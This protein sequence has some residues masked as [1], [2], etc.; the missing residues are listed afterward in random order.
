MTMNATT[1]DGSARSSWEPDGHTLTIAMALQLDALQRGAPEV[2]AGRGHLERPVRWVHV[3]EARDIASVLRGGELLMTEGG[4]FRGPEADQRRFVIELAERGVAG[5]ILELGTYFQSVPAQLIAE[6]DRLELPLIAWH[7]P[8]PFIEVTEAIHRWIVNAQSAL[9]IEGEAVQRRL[10][11]LALAGASADDLVEALSDAVANPVV[12][13]REGG[14]VAYVARA[15]QSERDVFAA[16]ERF[17]RQLPD[18]P[19][20]IQRDLPHVRGEALGRIVAI[21][22][23]ASLGATEETVM[24]RV[25]GLIS[26]VLWQSRHEEAVAARSNRGFLSALLAGEIAPITANNRAVSSGFSAPVLLPIAV[27][28]ARHHHGNMV[29][30]EDRIWSQVWQQ[31]ITE[32]RSRG[33]PAIVDPQRTS[34]P[35]LTVLGLS[36][37]GQRRVSAARFAS[38]VSGIAGRLYDEEGT[39]VVCVG[40]AV[41][42]WPSA[43]EALGVAV[44]A[45]QGAAFARPRL[46]HDA[47]D[48]D[49]DRLLWSLRD[50]ADLAQFAHLR[51]DR[52]ETHD[53][54]RH[55]QLVAT[56]EAFLEHNG[57]KADTARALHLERQSLYNRIERIES[58]LD[59]DLTDPDT[60]LSLHLALR[61]RSSLS[62]V[63]GRA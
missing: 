13:E 53:R 8:V 58:M 15:G 63:S 41:H 61:V 16:W 38:L 57:H 26:L 40:P 36:E 31:T 28:R 42:T 49:L 21:G 51:L 3:A 17:V 50:N 39:V 55:T 29:A 18:A 27:S 62:S 56:L 34:S 33:T 52:L 45:L 19:A 37:V 4:P 6:F 5:V 44:N 46:W 60:R 22:V 12:F 47:V 59:I 25:L 11:E 54:S 1:A 32:L 24:D 23:L 10:T 7:V 48:I 30:V 2:V 9:L 35:T 43:S 14:G 20:V